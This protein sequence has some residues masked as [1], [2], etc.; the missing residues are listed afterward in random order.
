MDKNYFQCPICKAKLNSSNK[1]FSSVRSVALHIA[2]K[3][4]G[5]D[6][7]HKM[8]AYENSGQEEIDQAL[9]Q[10]RATN[11]INVLADLMLL[12]LKAWHDERGKGNIGF[13]NPQTA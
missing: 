10:A 6:T 2:G 3:I 1:P 8:W 4:K 11:G 7:D 13:K 5:Q 9:A 12:P